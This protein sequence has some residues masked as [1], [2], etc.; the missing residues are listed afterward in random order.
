MHAFELRKYMYKYNPTLIIRTL[1]SPVFLET[2]GH[3]SARS[4][5]AVTTL[6]ASG[7]RAAAITSPPERMW[8]QGLGAFATVSRAASAN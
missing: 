5:Q 4:E 7:K 2:Y 1:L 3:G 8:E 6:E